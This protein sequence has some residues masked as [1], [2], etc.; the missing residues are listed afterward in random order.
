L[1]YWTNWK[2]SRGK[3]MWAPN[4]QRVDDG[5]VAVQHKN[6]CA[7][8]SIRLAR[9]TA[10][11][12]ILRHVQM[13]QRYFRRQQTE[14]EARRCFTARDSFISKCSASM[15]ISQNPTMRS[16]SEK[17][18]NTKSGILYHRSL[19]KTTHT[20]TDASFMPTE[21]SSRPFLWTEFS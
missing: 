12:D 8:P 2:I 4:S 14:T 18:H 13:L 21:K 19:R 15:R 9:R 7:N 6:C 20:C 1:Y 10:D 16:R 17:E 11:S 3:T 5:W